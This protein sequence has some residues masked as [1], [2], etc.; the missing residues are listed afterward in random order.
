MGDY[1]KIKFKKKI[2]ENDLMEAYAMG[3][4]KKADLVD[5]KYY[6]GNCRHASVAQWNE[7]QGCF[8]YMRE[9]FGALLCE[10]I[11][12]P[13][14]DDGYDLF[15]PFEETEPIPG[16]VIKKTD[17]SNYKGIVLNKKV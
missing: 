11:K 8:Y 7:N 15:T 4:L 13:E 1:P 5:G 10:S 16:E 14:D 2:T 6:A 3:M 9:K 17:Y 12:H